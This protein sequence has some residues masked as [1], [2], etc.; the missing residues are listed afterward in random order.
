MKENGLSAILQDNAYFSK[1]AEASEPE[2]KDITEEAA[3]YAPSKVEYVALSGSYSGG[4]ITVGDK[5]VATVDDPS[6][7]K[8]L[9]DM[10]LRN[11]DLKGYCIGK[12]DNLV[13]FPVS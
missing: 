11:L 4:V 8:G 9:E 6:S 7:V 5:A 10:E 13:I 1:D 3:S 12:G 2:A